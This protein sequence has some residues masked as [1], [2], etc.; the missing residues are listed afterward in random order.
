MKSKVN[1]KLIVL[2]SAVA[3]LCIWSAV[4]F[5]FIAKANDATILSGGEIESE[6]KG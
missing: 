4:M 5:S 3:M 2:L 6:Y 1:G